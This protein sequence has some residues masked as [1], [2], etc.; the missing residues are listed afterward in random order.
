MSLSVPE[1]SLVARPAVA[2]VHDYLTQR[3]GA[4][5]VVLTMLEAFPQAPVYTA[6]YEPALTFPEFTDHDVRPLWTNRIEALRRDHRKG[7]LLFPLVF[8]RLRVDAD[9]VLCSSSGF[10]H[11]VRTTGRKV[12]YCYTPA[13]WLYD[14]ADVYLGNWPSSVRLGVRTIAPVLRMWDRR[15]ARTAD[16]YLTSSRAMSDRIR[17]LYGMEAE[18][19]PPAPP[20]RSSDTSTPVAGVEPGFLLCVSRLMAY[21][22]VG[23]VCAAFEELPDRCLVVVGDGPSANQL[24]INAAPN[25]RFLGRV[26]DDELSWLYANCVGA[27]SASYEDFGLTAVEAASWGKPVAVLRWGGFLDTVVEDVTGVFIYSP[28]GP[29][30]AEAVRRLLNT[31]WDEASIVAQSEKFSKDSFLRRLVYVVNKP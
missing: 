9:V 22:N 10:A 13:R 6:L 19:V 12:V 2:I 4:E 23:A 16:A 1:G 31:S 8:S 27:V 25:V 14:Q 11:G 30:V 15:S 20:Q 29:Q 26:G 17:E 3:G 18:V 7:L 5:R 24:S 28:T 21:K